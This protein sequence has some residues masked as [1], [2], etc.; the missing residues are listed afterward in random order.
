MAMQEN[1]ITKSDGLYL[2]V[3]DIFDSTDIVYYPS[4]NLLAN[5]SYASGTAN[6]SNTVV[7]FVLPYYVIL[8]QLI[9][10]I[11]EYNTSKDITAYSWSVGSNGH[12]MTYDI[13][14]PYLT[15]SEFLDEGY[16]ILGMNSILQ[17]GVNLTS[18]TDSIFSET[19]IDTMSR[20]RWYPSETNQDTLTQTRISELYDYA[21]DYIANNQE[22][23]GKIPDEV[24]IKV[25][26][27]QL[28]IKYNQLFN[29]HYA[30]AIEIMNVDTRDLA[31]LMVADRGTVYKYYSYSFAR[32]TY[33]ESGTI[34][35]IFTALY[36]FVLWI[37]SIVKPLLMIA[38]LVLLII[39]AVFR[40]V[41]FRKESRCIEGYL[42]GCAC[43]CL[44]NY[45]YA[46]MLKITLSISEYGFGT[47]MSICTALFV[48]IAYIAGLSLIMNIMIK[49]WKN[50]GFNEYQT[51]GGT[52]MSGLSHMQTAIVDKMIAKQNT[53]YGDSKNSRKYVSDSYDSSSVNR[54]LE[55]DE[56]REENGTYSVI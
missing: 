21:R 56:E 50:N 25:F 17:T 22:V 16:D 5:Q 41:L 13:I 3:Q 26:A 23:L 11:D 40:K 35:V 4:S 6:E 24:F 32:F 1:V 28:A 49:D 51:I 55:R 27:L 38:M 19:Q 48:Q 42:I 46:F 7:S 29:V 9:A 43:L 39:N 44:C 31:R 52:I 33:E 14:A 47:I 2:N 8:D 12:I 37:T 34:G 20:S 15:S 45:A 10:N 30:N 53:A 18:Y 54:M 36:L